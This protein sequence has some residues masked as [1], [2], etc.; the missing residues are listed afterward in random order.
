MT[1]FIDRDGVRIA[2]D[3]QGS[4]E[5]L[6][7]V[8]GHRWSKRMWHPVIDQL[9]AHYRV[10]TFDNRGSGESDHVPA[11]YSVHDMADDALAVLHA[12][13]G[14]S[15]HV[16]GISM[17][18][19]IAQ[20]LAITHPEAVR[21][22]VLGC[23]APITAERWELNRQRRMNYY[24]PDKVTNFI[25]R[26][27]LYGTSKTTPAIAADWA[28]LAGERTTRQGLL[29]QAQA[30]SDYDVDLDAL[31]ALPNPTLV[32]HGGKDKVVPTAWGRELGDLIPNARVI[33]F[34]DA[35]H[36]YLPTH[37]AE[38]TAAVLEHLE[39]S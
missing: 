2:W 23:T 12:A 16:Y 8:M 22:L 30:V 39:R 27:L 17:G 33:V 24:L 9:A 37:A 20:D 34:D 25:G 35:G 3:A 38:S 28:M 1:E 29:G 21:K 31:R 32:L 15:A 7:L 6:L 14:Q 18:G 19:V 36:N 4:G 26:P 13:G 10:I 11:G 5:P